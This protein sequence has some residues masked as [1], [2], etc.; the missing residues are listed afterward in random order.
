MNILSVD[1]GLRHTGLAYLDDRIG[2][3]LPGDT[4]HHRTM[5]ELEEELLLII[6]DKKI[7]KVVFGL[8]LLP[9]GKE[10]SQ[11]EVVR[12][13][14]EGFPF[15]EGVTHSFIDERY[16]NNPDAENEDHA[17]AACAILEIYQ[18]RLKSI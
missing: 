14:T 13:F 18:D 3:V 8:P 16:T 7:S 5:P 12:T 9:S 15:P 11:A 1:L 4:I 2:I 17:G 6:R 10:G